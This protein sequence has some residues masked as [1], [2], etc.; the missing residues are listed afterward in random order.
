MG[1]ETERE[2]FIVAMRDEGM[3]LDIAKR[4]LRHANT[5]QRLAVVA[6]NGDSPW[7]WQWVPC[8][9]IGALG[10][11]NCLCHP[12]NTRTIE[13]SNGTTALVHG[14]VYRYVI[15]SARAERLVR[16]WC[17]KAGPFH[18]TCWK[19]IPSSATV[20]GL[21]TLPTGHTGEHNDNGG[22][23]F[24]PIFNGDP[25]GACTKLRVPSG[26]TDDWGGEGVCV[27]TRRY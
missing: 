7:L 27:P 3:S 23:P 1:Y 19:P 11:H 8:P 16:E 2:R 4:I 24:V 14:S 21:C 25:R 12:D 20:A 22:R 6:C 10:A 15:Q 5:I 13:Q 17:D 9:G 26:R 18:L